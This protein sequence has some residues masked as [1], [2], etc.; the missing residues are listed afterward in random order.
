[1]ENKRPISPHLQVYNIFS[2]EMTSGPSFLNR[3]TGIILT[4]G[5]IYFAAWL[6]TAA[7]GQG[8]YNIFLAFITSWFGWLSL[9]GFSCAFF[10]HLVN[11]LRFLIFDLGY[12]L[13]KRSMF[14]T[15]WGM[16]LITALLV[17]ITWVYICTTY[18]K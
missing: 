11:G 13:T 10:Y 4:V 3:A 7:I 5:L 15:G 2:K 16:V 6:I 1:M 12:F 8:A 17:I 9:F 14:L 18:I